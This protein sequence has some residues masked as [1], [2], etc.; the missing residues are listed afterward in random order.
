MENERADAGRDGRTRLVYQIIRLE[1]GYGKALFPGLA[2]HEQ[3]WQPYPVDPYSP[4][5]AGHTYIQYIQSPRHFPSLDFCNNAKKIGRG[6]HFSSGG[7]MIVLAFFEWLVRP[8][9]ELP[10]LVEFGFTEII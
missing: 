10:Q 1:R 8:G 7:D 6:L 3:D 5:S 9:V 2:D 4:E